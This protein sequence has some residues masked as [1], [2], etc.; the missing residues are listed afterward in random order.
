MRIGLPF[1]TDPLASNVS[2]PELT[3]GH[4]RNDP[5]CDA[6]SEPVYGHERLTTQSAGVAWAEL[7]QNFRGQG[8]TGNRTCRE[9]QSGGKRLATA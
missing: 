3:L 7:N 8:R 4:E 1:I 5:I 9:N 2:V 6:G